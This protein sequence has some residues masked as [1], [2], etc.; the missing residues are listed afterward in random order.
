M[1]GG[2]GVAESAAR[3]G[4]GVNALAEIGVNSFLRTLSRG[5]RRSF[6]QNGAI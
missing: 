5:R 6:E 4:P 2:A 1:V 3:Y